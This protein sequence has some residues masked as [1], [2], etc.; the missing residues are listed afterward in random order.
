MKIG[1]AQSRP[2]PVAKGVLGTS[3]AICPIAQLYEVQAGAS[4][5]NI[6]PSFKQVNRF[7]FACA[8]AQIE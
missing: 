5:S 4:R 8:C 1:F 6:A 2:S 7:A 3:H